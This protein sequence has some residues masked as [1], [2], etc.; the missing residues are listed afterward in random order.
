MRYELISLQQ[1][2]Y[3]ISPIQY[4]V[5]FDR[6]WNSRKL[7]FHIYEKNEKGNSLC[8]VFGMLDSK[9]EIC[10]L[11]CPYPRYQESCYPNFLW[12]RCTLFVSGSKIVTD[13]RLKVY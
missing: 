2:N 4:H 1:Q 7:V 9:N 10:F 5:M 11:R 13:N 12:S 3:Q 8:T 6:D